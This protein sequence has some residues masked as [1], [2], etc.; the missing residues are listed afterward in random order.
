MS[1]ARP[2]TGKNKR[3]SWIPCK[4][5]TETKGCAG[6]HG[7][8][9]TLFL[10]F[11]VSFYNLNRF[12]VKGNEAGAYAAPEPRTRAVTALDPHERNLLDFMNRLGSR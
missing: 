3:L 2:N 11:T 6:V 9:A 10:L 12:V 5:E 4:G 1:P 8:S 7:L